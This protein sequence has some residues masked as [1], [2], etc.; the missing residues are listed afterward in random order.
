MFLWAAWTS[1]AGQ[2]AEVDASRPSLP[3]P[4]P[5]TSAHLSPSAASY[6]YRLAAPTCIPLKIDVSLKT[7]S[8]TWSGEAKRVV[9]ETGRAE[10][11]ATQEDRTLE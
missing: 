5:A 8:D 7:C 10:T 4:Q 9:E 6:R 1:D 2:K 11:E 3:A